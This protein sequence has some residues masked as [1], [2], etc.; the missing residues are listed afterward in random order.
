MFSDLIMFKDIADTQNT[1]DYDCDVRITAIF[2]ARK[3]NYAMSARECTD[4][5]VVLQL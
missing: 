4:L 5:Y 1:L 2:L 3:V